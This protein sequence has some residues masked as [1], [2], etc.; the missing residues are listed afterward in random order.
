MKVQLKNTTT[1]EVVQIKVGWS[2][3][4]FFFAGFFGLPLFLRKLHVW[5]GVFFGLLILDLVLINIDPILSFMLFLPTMMGMSIWIAIKGNEMTAKNFL[6][7]G[8]EFVDP[9]S[10]VVR[11]AKVRWGLP[12]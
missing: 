3:T 8:Y 10:D 6:E 5:G 2:W 9:D 4:L 11:F 12:T 7:R 1:G